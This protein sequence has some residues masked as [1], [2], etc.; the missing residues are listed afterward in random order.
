MQKIPKDYWLLSREEFLQ[1]AR[2]FADDLYSD[3]VSQFD[4]GAKKRGMVDLFSDPR[5]FGYIPRG[6][7][8]YMEFVDGFANYGGVFGPE[9]KRRME[10]IEKGA[11]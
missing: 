2:T 6:S 10:R 11:K 1:L 9:R 3:M 8:C 7:E 5:E 4:K